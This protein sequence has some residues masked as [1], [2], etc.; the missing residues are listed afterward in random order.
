MEIYSEGPKRGWRG[1]GYVGRPQER[2]G[3]SWKGIGAYVEGEICE[4]VYFRAT[5]SR[6]AGGILESPR[7]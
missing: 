5:G 7:G 3:R 2:S 4:Q 1:A 6:Y